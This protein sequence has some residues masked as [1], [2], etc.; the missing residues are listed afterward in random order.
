MQLE[1]GAA[2]SEGRGAVG[3]RCE[4]GVEVQLE[5]RVREDKYRCR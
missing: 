2:G 1:V 4:V 5:V 3:G